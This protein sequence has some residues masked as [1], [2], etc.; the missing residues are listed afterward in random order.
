[1][2]GIFDAHMH[3]P[4]ASSEPLKDLCNAMNRNGITQAMVILNG[5]EEKHLFEKNSD[6]FL[7]YTDTFCAASS[8]DLNE[9]YPFL[10][11]ENWISKGFHMFIKLHPRLSNIQKSNFREIH[12]MLSYLYCS[13]V[14]IDCFFYGHHLENH[15]GIELGIYLAEKLPKTNFVLAHAGGFRMLECMLYTRTL[16]NIYYDISLS[17]N[18]LYGASTHIDMIQLLKFNSHRTMYGSDY[19]DFL[20]SSAIDN[21]KALSKGANLSDKQMD[22]IFRTNAQN[23]YQMQG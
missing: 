13:T 9:P 8:L 1:M 16:P 20:P 22:A 10:F 23:V 19:P 17:C 7:S 12:K 4:I 2:D 11:L 15:I 5:Q 6:F 21:V 14:I 3:F 18:Y